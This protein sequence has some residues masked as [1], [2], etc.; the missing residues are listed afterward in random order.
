VSDDAVAV[1]VTQPESAD[2]AS[3]DV[4]APAASETCAPAA[5]HDVELGLDESLAQAT[6]SP[7]PPAQHSVEIREITGN[8]NSV[9]TRTMSERPIPGLRALVLIRLR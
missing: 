4:Y 1:K 9:V 5:L 2:L 6:T 7:N 8:Q 3:K